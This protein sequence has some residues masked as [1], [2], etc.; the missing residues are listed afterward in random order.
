[1]LETGNG[2]LEHGKLIPDLG[3]PVGF[4]VSAAVWYATSAVKTHYFIAPQ[5]DAI[6]DFPRKT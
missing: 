2:R 3:T 6:D 5:T 4:S 1:M